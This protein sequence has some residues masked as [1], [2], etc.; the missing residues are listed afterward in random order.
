M[1]RGF[2]L[3]QNSRDE[4]QFGEINNGHYEH[5]GSEHPGGAHFLLGDGAV[6]FVSEKT[7]LKILQ[8]Y[9]TRNYREVVNLDQP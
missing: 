3:C 5:P 1:H 7:E 2:G 8:A 4:L 9:A 6:R